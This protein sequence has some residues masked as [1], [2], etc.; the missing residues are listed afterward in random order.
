MDT[1]AHTCILTTSFILIIS[2]NFR[3]IRVGWRFDCSDAELLLRVTSSGVAQS[4]TDREHVDLFWQVKTTAF[5]HFLIVFATTPKFKL[6]FGGIL[7]NPNQP[8]TLCLGDAS[9][10]RMSLTDLTAG[11]GTGPVD[12]SF[13]SS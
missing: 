4:P 5:Q 2:Y 3:I 13:F 6:L 7:G 9:A 11:G 8:P 12:F 1:L 10:D